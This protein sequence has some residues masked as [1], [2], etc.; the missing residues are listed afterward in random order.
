MPRTFGSL[1]LARTAWAWALLILGYPSGAIAQVEIRD[2]TRPFVVLDTGGHSGPVRSILYPERDHIISGGMDKLI[3]SWNIADGRPTLAATIRPAIW[4]GLGGVIYTMALSPKADDKGRRILAVGGYGLWSTRGNITLFHYPGDPAAPNGE[5]LAVLPSHIESVAKSP[6][7]ADTVTSLAFSPDGRTLASSANDGRVILWDVA[8]RRVLADLKGPGAPINSLAF[9]PDGLRLAAG[10][11]D[12][13][14]R[15]WDVPKRVLLAE[16]SPTLQERPEALKADV[17]GDVILCLAFAHA[18]GRSIVIGRESGVLTRYD[19]DTLA[20]PTPLPEPVG[21]RRGPV[22]ALAVSHDGNTLAAAIITRPIDRHGD[23][24]SVDCEVQ[25]R[26]MADGKRLDSKIVADNLIQALAFS[27]DDTQLAVAGGDSQAIKIYS[28][29]RPGRAVLALEGRGK[30]VWRVGFGADSRT[31]GLS[32]DQEPGG[33]KPE[34]IGFQLKTQAIVPADSSSSRRALTTWD[35]WK[36]TPLGPLALRVAGPGR[37]FDVVLDRAIDRR[38]WAYS[39]IPPGPKHEKPTLAVAC[40]AGLVFFRL[41]DGVR[42][43]S[44]AGH[45]SSVYDLAPSPDGMW[46]AT[47]SADQTVR[48]WSLANCDKLPPLGATFRRRADGRV[49]VAAVARRGFAEGMGLLVGDILEVLAVGNKKV[50]SLDNLAALDAVTP[51]VR[52]EFRVR[53]GADPVE[54]GTSRRDSPRLS[55]F[56][57]ED[58]EW[59]VWT[60]EGYYETSVAGDRKYLGWHRNGATL[61][62]PTDR[63]PAETFEKEFRRPDVIAALIDADDPAQA[64]GLV[65]GQ[66]ADPAAIVAAQAPPVISLSV[67]VPRPRNA[68]IPLPAGEVVVRAQVTAEGRSPI[69]SVQVLVDGRP[70]QPATR[71]PVPQD[72]SDVSVKVPVEGAQK[73]S[74]VVTN[75]DGKARTVGFDALAAV[76]AKKVPTLHVVAIGVGGPFADAKFPAIPHAAEDARRLR[77]FFA[78][79]DGKKRFDRVEDVPALVDELATRKSVRDAFLDLAR[80]VQDPSDSLVVVLESH[81]LTG[82]KDKFVIAADM[83]AKPRADDAPTADEIADVLGEVA[84]RGCKVF[85]LLDTSHENAPKECRAGLVDFVRSVSR[86]NVITFVAASYGVSHP[87]NNGRGAFAQAILDVSNARATARPLVDP[88]KPM[89]LDDFQDAVVSR[90]LEL[91]NRKQFAAC[92]IPDKLSSSL[93]IFE[94]NRPRN[95]AGGK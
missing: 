68:P 40:D 29:N 44:F 49:E 7:H 8:A 26:S 45:S 83:P 66:N 74:V 55:L 21:V 42:T 33:P 5:V 75:R 80:A 6:G 57:G 90:V 31:V 59:V 81:V 25:L 63:F 72:A 62:R 87:T 69:T 86:R 23:R 34:T 78:A 15:L 11:A 70:V 16:K 54:V 46:L 20:N 17:E 2:F 58:R 28:L 47:G 50:E 51:G 56:V 36:V 77:T 79:P 71:F 32:H 3:H 93:L 67:N 30:S 95:L 12:G 22:E 48:I 60:P 43:R 39:F 14:V 89:T 65:V 13:I 9:R 10:G 94:P 82:S 73:V 91:T 19:G 53:R 27:P 64:F 52:V 18:D 61:D 88:S 1:R 4:R 35:G 41:E 85:L 84:K 92:Y 37:T 76:D 38:W 24:P